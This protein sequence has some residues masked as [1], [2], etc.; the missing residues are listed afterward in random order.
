MTSTSIGNVLRGGLAAGLILTLYGCGG[1]S[2]STSVTPGGTQAQQSNISIADGHPGVTPFI[3]FVRISGQSV[4]YVSSLTFTISPMPNS[5]SQPVNVTWSRAALSGSGYLKGNVLIN[6]PVFGLYAGYQNQVSFQ[7]AFVDGSVQQLQYQISTEPYTDPTGVY[8]NPTI[9]KARAPGSNLGFNFFILK[10]LLGSPV[11][12]DTDGQV[13]W[14]VPAGGTAASYF[15]NGQFV[16][17]S[18]TSASVTLLQLD[19]TQSALP[20]HLPQPVLFSFTHNIDPG[21]SGL[22][23][24]FNGID[25]LG[26]SIGDI[27]AEISPFSSQPPI[28]TFDMAV[29]LTAY[30]QNNGDNPSA[31]VRP[32]ADWFHVN[33]ST[34]D[35]SDNTV[36]ISSRENFLIKVNYSTHDIVWILGD[37]TKYWYTFP[38]LRAKALTLDAGGDYPIGQH[39]V[40]ITSEGYVMVFNDGL[41]SLNQ[42]PG[43]P[44][45]LS[46]TYSEV[47]AYSVNAATMTAQNVWNFNYG[48]SIY[49]PVCGSSYEAPGNTYLVDYATADNGAEARL[50]GLD[51]NQ[52]VVFD[53]QYASPST[54]GAAWNAIPVPMENLQIVP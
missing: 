28:Q 11:I 39:A 29:I 32:G 51:A 6:L 12:V 38:S 45:G 24:E 44:A 36:I 20:T 50:V 13:R 34:Y 26:D 18:G 42:P 37:P 27:V 5:V 19:G 14:V 10:S 8:L 16:T 22:L 54:C 25:V 47:S 35:P 43:E 46:R 17:G 23:A 4:S 49:S 48:Q 33:A 2:G 3:S 15:A 9:V 40:S 31:F 7:L 21:P 41:G 52:N 30:M 1:G 53:F